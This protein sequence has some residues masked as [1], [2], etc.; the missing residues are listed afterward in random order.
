L[1]SPPYDSSTENSNLPEGI[2]EEGNAL[3][4]REEGAGANKSS[5]K[6]ESWLGAAL[7][8]TPTG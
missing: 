1:I 2:E 3:K 7:G 6:K 5:N 8:M 4:G